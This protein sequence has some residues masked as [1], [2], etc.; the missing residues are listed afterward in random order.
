MPSELIPLIA[1]G[2][3]FLVPIV[4]ILVTHQRKM[5]ELIHG[6]HSQ[7]HAIEPLVAEV[8]ALRAELSQMRDAVNT[9]ILRSDSTPPLPPEEQVRS[10]S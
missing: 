7:Q 2:G 8:R 4:A 6:S 9:S 5:A 3:A 10:N 1:V